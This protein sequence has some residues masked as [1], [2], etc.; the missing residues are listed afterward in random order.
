MVYKYFDV[1]DFSNV[2]KTEV[3]RI[4]RVEGKIEVEG[5]NTSGK[6]ISEVEFVEGRKKGLM[7]LNMPSKPGDSGSPIVDICGRLI[8]VV[9]GGSNDENYLAFCVPWLK[10]VRF[11]KSCLG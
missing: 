5:G 9:N 7:L 6:V 10:I 1:S 11:L 2:R 4:S 8:G 3:V